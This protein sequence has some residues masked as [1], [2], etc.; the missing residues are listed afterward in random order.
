MSIKL[1]V[2]S[3]YEPTQIDPKL[4]QSIHR[5]KKLNELF[6]KYRKDKREIN[7]LYDIVDY[8][9]NDIKPKEKVQDVFTYDLD[10]FFKE[11]RI[12]DISPSTIVEDIYDCL[13][14]YGL[15]FHLVHDIHPVTKHLII[16][17][18]PLI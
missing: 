1:G 3:D 11:L 15:E 16:T 5:Q 6:S 10:I 17:I 8:L 2:D 7:V 12:T 9:Y 4:Q 13:L 18:A 14:E